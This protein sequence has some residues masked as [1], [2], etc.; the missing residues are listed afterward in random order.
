MRILI[1]EDESAHAEAIRRS[2]EKAG[3]PGEIRVAG[4]LSEYRRLRE[5]WTPDVALVDM[6][7]PDGRA[8]E[9]LTSPLEEGPFPI[10]IMTSHGSEATVVEALKAGALDYVVKSS[11]S[12]AAISRIL[13]RALREWNLIREKERAKNALRDSE[14]LF[15]TVVNTS[16]ALVWMSDPEG[17]CTW[18]NQPWLDF[19]GRSL[20]QERG[21]GWAEGVHPEDRDRCMETYRRACQAR[22]PFSMEYRLRRRDGLYRW[23]LDRG[24]PRQ[25]EKGRFL[26]YIGSCLD[27]SERKQAEAE[28]D[29]AE[30]DLRQ[31]QKMEAV[32]RLAGGVAHDFNNMLH[33]IL[34][35]TDLALAAVSP[36][37]PVHRDLQEVR[38]AA[39]RSADLTR[40][41]L[42]F[43]RKQVV[44]PRVLDLNRLIED[45][46]KM[47]RRLIGEEI[48]IRFLPGEG[49]WPLRADPSQIDQILANLA[50]NARDAIGGVGTIAIET[51][52]ATLD[53][54]DRNGHLQA[55][56]GDYVRLSFSDTGCGMDEETRERIFEPFFTTKGTGRGT[57]LGLATIYGIVRQNEGFIDVVSRPGEGSTFRLYF[58]R[59]SGETQEAD[60][61]P[62]AP[63]GGFETLLVVEDE[64]Q[65]RNLAETVLRRQGYRVLSAS[66]PDEALRIV[67]EEVEPIHLLVTD[68]IMPRM[69]GKELSERV[70]RLK[71]E[72]RTLFMSGYAAEV[73]LERGVLEPDIQF[74]QK[75]FSLRALAAKV[76]E[77]LDR[78]GPGDAGV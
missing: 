28:R 44:S 76:R 13:E 57:G 22:M 56:P 2:L 55:L 77:V 51:G 41:L 37:S 58:P 24:H 5:E 4:S 17:L 36:D 31:A 50:V 47:L 66:D 12:F 11:E 39:E 40:Q 62:E 8:V 53:G 33:V 16:P 15:S 52:N 63:R 29:R 10:L 6:N 68:V 38:R 42:A 23:I 18:F 3:N 27:I 30:A 35:Y 46:R 75:P 74:I 34:G 32:G 45:S 67:E 9:I 54:S 61:T 21:N 71:P 1:V 69:N 26:G 70:G 7:L 78:R 72:I 25:D 65:V 20:D 19:T 14:R 64:D 60:E 59:Y 43:S 73:I 48:E 49:L